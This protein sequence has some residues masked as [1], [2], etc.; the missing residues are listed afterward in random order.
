MNINQNSETILVNEWQLGQALNHAVHSNAREKFNLLLS[1]LSEDARDFAQ[2][3]YLQSESELKKEDS[4]LRQQF[5][6]RESQPLVNSGPTSAQ[7]AA[8]NDQLHQGKLT[9]IR[10]QQLLDN[11][12]MLSRQSSSIFPEEVLD[13]LS[14]IKRDKVANLYQ[15]QQKQSLGVDAQLLD[16]YDALDLAN[17][18]ITSRQV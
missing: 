5:Q 7:L 9:E 1:F 6:L 10:L 11:E 14:L 16:E 13:N 17:K 3:E 4:S 15:A 2:F 12:A 8:Y 18:P